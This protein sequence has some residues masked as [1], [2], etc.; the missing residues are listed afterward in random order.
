M[1]CH[2]ILPSFKIRDCAALRGG[3][4]ALGPRACSCLTDSQSWWG[5][6]RETR[7]LLLCVPGVVMEMLGGVEMERRLPGGSGV[8]A[9][10]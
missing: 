5:G 6:R 9:A 8:W 2:L 3:D 1:S 10:G 4:W 7:Q